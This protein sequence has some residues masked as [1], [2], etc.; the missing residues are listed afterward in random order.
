MGW[1]VRMM[2][3]RWTHV[4]KWFTLTATPFKLIKAEPFL[5]ASHNCFIVIEKKTN[6]SLD[7]L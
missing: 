7:K 4:Y 1:H 6:I 5:F 3:S 2:V